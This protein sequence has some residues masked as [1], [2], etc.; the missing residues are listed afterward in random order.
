[1]VPL[2]MIVFEVLAEDVSKVG[3]AEQEDVV[4]AVGADGSRCVPDPVMRRCVGRAW[5]AGP[6]PDGRTWA[7]SRRSAGGARSSSV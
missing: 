6:S 3:F 7:A 5:Q 1:M 2:P 4:E